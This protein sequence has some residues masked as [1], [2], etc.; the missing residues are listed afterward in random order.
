MKWMLMLSRRPPESSRLP[1]PSTVSTVVAIVFNY[2]AMTHPS[3][4]VGTSWTVSHNGYNSESI[5][6]RNDPPLGCLHL[7]LAYRYYFALRRHDN[8]PNCT[9]ISMNTNYERIA[10]WGGCHWRTGN[11]RI[12]ETP[13]AAHYQATGHYLNQFW[14]SSATHI[15]GTR[16]RWINKRVNE[17]LANF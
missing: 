17:W 3:K 10:L 11:P 14:P 15:C 7:A 8:M 5:L 6:G 12:L 16:G 4:R 2:S 1:S 9:V 13:L